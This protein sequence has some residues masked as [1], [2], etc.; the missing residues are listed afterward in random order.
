MISEPKHFHQTLFIWR[1]SVTLIWIF[2]VFYSICKLERNP[3]IQIQMLPSQLDLVLHDYNWGAWD[4]GKRTTAS[5][6]LAWSIQQDAVPANK[7]SMYVCGCAWGECVMGTHTS[8]TTP[9]WVKWRNPYGHQNDLLPSF[10][11]IPNKSAILLRPSKQSS[12]LLKTV[13]HTEKQ[14]ISSLGIVYIW[15]HPKCL[16]FCFLI[17][18]FF[19]TRTSLA[20]NS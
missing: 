14:N 3:N 12:D 9:Q 2:I 8:L 13:Y 11:F 16:C 4:K 7:Q 6:V 10:H 19:E 5:L 20:L 18:F 15:T 1:I 17:F